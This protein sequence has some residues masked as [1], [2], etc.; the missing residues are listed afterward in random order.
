MSSSPYQSSP[1]FQISQPSPVDRHSTFIP[2]PAPVSSI[3]MP[4]PPSSSSSLLSSSQQQTTRSR[5]SSSPLA[6][7]NRSPSRTMPTLHRHHSHVPK[8]ASVDETRTPVSVLMAGASSLTG[9]DSSSTGAK[10]NRARSAS[11]VTMKEVGVGEGEN[12]MADLG[13][14]GTE[15]WKW[16]DGKGAWIIHI[17]LILV[18]KV[19]FDSIPGIGHDLS[20]TLV[21]CGYMMVTYL[22]FHSMTG[23]PF[24]NIQ[25]T[26]GAY[27]DL[28]LWEQIDNG[29]QYTPAKKWLTS[30]PIGL[31]LI[32]THYTKYE[33]VLFSVNVGAVVCV[34]IPKL[35]ALHR[36]RF[37]FFEAPME[38]PYPSRPSSPMKGRSEASIPEEV[39][40]EVLIGS[41]SAR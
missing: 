22:I 40:D 19:L 33:P 30:V 13:S 10:R 24:E 8:G 21:N 17:I 4:S 12:D 27:D 9:S 1:K 15:N 6:F 34:L 5:S 25:T 16:V 32:S 14:S 41:R 37:R 2:E 38:T 39:E 36:L 31:F 23:L 3:A 18:C 35:P 29:A 20:W 11:L 26:G 7:M 28:T